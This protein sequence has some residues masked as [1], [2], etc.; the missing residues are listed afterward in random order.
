MQINQLL[1]MA[2]V[3]YRK[4]IKDALRDK[5]SLRT[6]LLMPLYFVAIFVG[7]VLFAV[8]ANDDKKIAG[9]KAVPIY[10]Q[11]EQ[12]LPELGAWLREQGG[13]LRSIEGDAF[14]QVK[15]KKIDFALII[16]KDAQEKK[17]QGQPADVWLIYDAANQKI[18]SSLGF[19]RAECRRFSA[20][21][22]ALQLMARGIAPDV[23]QGARI[24]E[25]NLADE[26]KMSVYLLASLPMTLML[27]VFAASIGFSA[28][29]TAGERERRSLESLLITPA[30]A[31]SVVLGKWLTSLSLTSVVILIQLLLLAIAFHYL[32]FDQLGLRVSVDAADLCAVFF[33]LLSVSVFA[34][35]LQVSLSIFAKS[36]KD[37]QSI[38]AACV[39]IP[40]ALNIYTLLNP[41]VHYDWW[42]W[43]PVLGQSLAVKD[44]LL[45]GVVTLQ[46][47]GIFWLVGCLA[48]LAP[49]WVCVKWLR[50]PRIVYPY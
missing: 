37:A 34:V 49:L 25:Y 27:V 14:E 22:G 13:V 43:V 41:S 19:V 12:F 16:A 36:F 10:I 40:M 23:S 47:V 18:S 50:H 46:A 42:L 8:Q 9:I 4:E 32:P 39:F 6:A 5:R 29:M 21:A 26:Q 45:G 2:W 35:A 33:V 48:A 38:F 20:H 11:G 24:H 31:I 7:I 30:S 44:I 28:D 3:V 1:S 17:A 15:H